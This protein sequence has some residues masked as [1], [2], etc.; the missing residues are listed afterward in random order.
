MNPFEMVV[1]IVG[2]GA[3]ANFVR[4]KNGL[5]TGN[6]WGGRRGRDQ[7]LAAMQTDDT[8]TVRLREEVKELK[9][10]LHVL[11]RIATDTNRAVD[12]DREIERLR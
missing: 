1:M 3:V 10:R 5:P 4:A 9:E 12:L 11:E 6:F 7:R 2:I 8:E